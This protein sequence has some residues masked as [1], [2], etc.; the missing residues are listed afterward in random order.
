MIVRVQSAA[1]LQNGYYYEYETESAPLGEGGMGRV[2]QGYCFR[3]DSRDECIPVA[4]KLITNPSQDL[5]ERAMREAS[6]Q[7]ENENLLRMY[8]FI[9]NYETDPMTGANVI[10][11]YI[12]MEAL[13][14]INLDDVINGRLVDKFGRVCEYG[15]ELYELY[16][17]NRYEFVKTIMSNV[18]NGVKALHEAGYIHRDI[19][20]SNVM[21]THSRQIKLIDYGIS[22]NLFEAASGKH[23][24][25]TTGSIMG[26]IDY[27]APE[28][29]TGDVNNHNVTTD[30]YALGITA[31]QLFVGSVPFE[32]DN[33][34]V[35]KQQLN[36]P[37]PVKNISNAILRRLVEKATLKP[38][39]DRYQ[40]ISEIIDDYNRLS[41]D[42]DEKEC[43]MAFRGLSEKSSPR[44]LSAFLTNYPMSKY[45]QKVKTWLDHATEDYDFN[46]ISSHSDIKTLN[47]Y[48]NKWP[49]GKH[50]KTVTK[51]VSKRTSGALHPMI[52]A[53]ALL[54]SIILGFCVIYFVIR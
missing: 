53:A 32:G 13:E 25:T 30:I 31:Y 6:V 28:M 50:T 2:Y 15:R 24:L 17:T 42:T 39:A 18:L 52:Y 46:Q 40:S 4:L 49:K 10:R 1:E 19:D 48:L 43:E 51:W 12:A 34:T 37:I 8:G 26:K 9:P 22:K 36:T 7:I 45:E 35:A 23:K 5:I 47:A 44:V 14:G 3:E 11:Y 20:P 41:K 27:A 29:I 33:A 38:Q 21:I 54:T 16:T